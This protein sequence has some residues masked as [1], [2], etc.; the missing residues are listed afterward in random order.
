MPTA[1]PDEILG[2]ALPAQPTTTRNF[3]TDDVLVVFAEVYDNESASRHT[4]DIT[5]TLRAVDGCVVFQ[6]SE[7]RSSDDLDGAR[8]GYGNAALIPLADMA[9]GEYVLMTEA[10]SRLRSAA[11]AS[12][13]LG[14]TIRQRIN[15]R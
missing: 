15:E 14:L 12:G 5:T 10:R 13:Q 7:E 9:P 3:S 4:V 6:R 11:T 2:R 1:Q 8:S